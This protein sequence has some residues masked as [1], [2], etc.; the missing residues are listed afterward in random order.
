MAS[1]IKNPARINHHARRMYFASDHALRLN[2]HA[3]FRENYAVKSPCDDHAIPFNLPFNFCLFAQYHRVLRNNIALHNSVNAKRS[4]DL[5]RAFQRHPLIYKPGP[6]FGNVVTRCAGPF[7]GHESPLDRDSSTLVS[8][9]AKSTQP[10]P[11][12][13]NAPLTEWPALVIHPQWLQ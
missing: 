4:G 8:R 12:V 3:P 2:F 7:P 5:E 1:P 9:T 11:K 13:S 6:F 10:V